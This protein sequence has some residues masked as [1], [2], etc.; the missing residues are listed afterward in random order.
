M[1]PANQFAEDI[2]HYLS[3]QPVLACPPSSAYKFRK[4]ARRNKA[5]LVTTAAIL[6]CLV[7]GIFATSW[8]AIRATTAERRAK[9]HL[10]AEQFAREQAH[11]AQQ[12][13]AQQRTVAEQQRDRAE[14]NLELATTEQLRA[15][16]N[17]DLAMEALDAVYLKAIGEEKLL[18]QPRSRPPS[19]KESFL[20]QA[21]PPLTELEKELLRRGLDFY[22]EFSLRNGET[23]QAILPTANAY[24]R[25]ALLQAA[26]GDHA[27]AEPNYR[28]AIERFTRLSD[29]EPNTVSHLLQLASTYRGLA[30]S[31]PE[32]PA[33]KETLRRAR[34]VYS[35]A[36]HLQPND[37]QLYKERANI[38]QQ[39]GDAEQR[40]D[41]LVRAV[42]FA[43]DDV[44]I[45]MACSELYLYTPIVDR[46]DGQKAMQLAERAVSLAPND[47]RTHLQLA[48]A[49]TLTAR[50]PIFLGLLTRSPHIR[51]HVLSRT[52]TH[53]QRAIELAPKHPEPLIARSKFY[54]EF[55][56]NESAL[57]D[58]DR[59][60]ELGV[61]TYALLKTRA[62]VHRRLGNSDAALRDLVALRS[63]NPHS[64]HV[65]CEIGFVHM[66][67]REWPEALEVFTQ[68][69]S[70]R[71]SY[72]VWYKHRARA[73]GRLGRYEDALDDMA[74]AL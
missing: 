68:A 11:R 35:K 62:R 34:D 40:F 47:F 9:D 6:L 15:E 39:M 33:A 2:E 63:E 21:H 30:F 8:Q 3:D 10:S 74:T 13:E 70:I 54:W 65:H 28:E 22:D 73:N 4:F 51:K 18:G 72:W 50:L 41:D 48:H 64:A 31:L 17:L 27:E 19:A 25:V 32:W 60:A 14:A 16:G 20:H 23:T 69:I 42:Q 46:R 59:A 37:A 71:S 38:S 7:V 45:C 44:A 5:A 56:D 26:L 53:Y 43:P 24:Y 1:E 55:G 49:R 36:L 29:E 66:Q 12:A 61:K 57:D 67:R 58:L 52:L